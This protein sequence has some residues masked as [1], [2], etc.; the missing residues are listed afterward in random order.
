MQ[1]PKRNKAGTRSA[2]FYLC[3]FQ[4]NMNTTVVALQG[5]HVD[6][7]SSETVPWLFCWPST[8]SI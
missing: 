5:Q 7:E 2:Y 4:A 3:C 8:C 6:K 1:G